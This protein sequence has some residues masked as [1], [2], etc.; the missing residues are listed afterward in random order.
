MAGYGD[1]GTVGSTQHDWVRGQSTAGSTQ[2]GWVW[3]HRYSRV[4]PTW[5][6]MGTQVQLGLPNMT[7]YGDTGTAGSA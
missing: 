3:G 1:T 6:G 2:H 7:G 5:L 4:C